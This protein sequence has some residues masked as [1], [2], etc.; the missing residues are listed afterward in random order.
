MDWIHYLPRLSQAGAHEL[1]AL[2]IESISLIPADFPLSSGLA[3]G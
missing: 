2:D 3:L 1:K